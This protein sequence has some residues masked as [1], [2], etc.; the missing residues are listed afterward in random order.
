MNLMDGHVFS[1]LI[2][3]L[4]RTKLL[5]PLALWTVERGLKLLRP[6]RPRSRLHSVN[7]S[8]AIPISTLFFGELSTGSRLPMEHKM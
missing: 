3:A 6:L 7:R 2:P 4:M 5:Y 1:P 8:P